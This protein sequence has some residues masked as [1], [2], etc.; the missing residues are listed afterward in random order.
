MKQLAFFLVLAATL[1]ALTT[2]ATTAKAQENLPADYLT[3][4]FHAGRRQALRDL[5]PPNSVVVVFPIL[6][7]SL[8][9]SMFY[10]TVWVSQNTLQKFVVL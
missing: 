1:L 2:T 6:P 9:S 3:P 4:A 5:M 10:E 7:A 8:L